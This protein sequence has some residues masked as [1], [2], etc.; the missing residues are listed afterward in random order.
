MAIPMQAASKFVRIAIVSAGELLTRKHGHERDV[1]QSSRQRQHDTHQHCN[2]RE[3]DG[4]LRMIRER[5]E[6]LGAGQDMEPD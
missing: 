4:T 2:H 3:D 5:V 6:D 1:A